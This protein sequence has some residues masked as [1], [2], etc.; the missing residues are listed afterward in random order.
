MCRLRVCLAAVGALI[1][2]ISTASAFEAMLGGTFA[3]HP[4]PNSRH[5]IMLLGAGEIV[6]IDRCNHGWC[7]VRHGEHTGYVYMPRVLDGNVYGPGRGGGGS[8]DG[9]ADVG[10][11]VVTAPVRAAGEAVD[12]GV[13]IL[14]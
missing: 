5:H 9:F 4:R 12:A 8:D 3:L 10:A 6:D 1:G 2:L 14:R 7:L 13:S 11:G